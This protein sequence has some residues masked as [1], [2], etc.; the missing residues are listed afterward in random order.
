MFESLARQG[1]CLPVGSHEV[2]KSGAEL[3]AQ[4][5]ES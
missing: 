1:S 2:E 4:T 5:M 3:S